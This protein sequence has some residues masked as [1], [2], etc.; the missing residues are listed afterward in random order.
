MHYRSLFSAMDNN[1]IR[2]SNI[3]FG[4]PGRPLLLNKLN[5]TLRKG[6]RVGLTGPNGSGKTTLLHIIMGLV[7]PKEGEIEIL[8]KKRRE[9]NDFAEVR[10]KIGLLFQHSDDQ[11]FC[12]MVAED[13]AF[14]PLN[15]GK[16]GDEVKVI[17]K[18]A[19]EAV[20]LSGFEERVPYDLSGGEKRKLCMATVLAM[21]PEIL[22]LDEPLL[23]LDEDARGKILEILTNTKLSYII[24]SE[25][26][27][28]LKT[29]T[30]R[31]YQIEDGYLRRIVYQIC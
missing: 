30:N 4:Y 8:G 17:V 31:V 9:E 27:H 13:V 15:L 5:F 26:M 10:G 29:T 28:F 7:K 1:L 22:L 12:P 24:V 19:L 18:E 23:E 16:S 11:L 14:G 2:L 20:G 6:E 25:D 3:T 21:G